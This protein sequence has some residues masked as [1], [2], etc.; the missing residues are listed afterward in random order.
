MSALHLILFFAGLQSMVISKDICEEFTRNGFWFDYGL[1]VRNNDSVS[2]QWLIIH[3]SQTNSPMAWRVSIDYNNNNNT[4]QV[5]RESEDLLSVHGLNITKKYVQSITLK[6]ISDVIPWTIYLY[7]HN[8]RLFDTF[9]LRGDNV[10]QTS[11]AE[12]HYEYENTQPSVIYRVIRATADFEMVKQVNYSDVFVRDGTQAKKFLLND[13]GRLGLQQ[14]SMPLIESLDRMLGV[15]AVFNVV[16]KLLIV[17]NYHKQIKY[18]ISDPQWIV[19]NCHINHFDTT[20]SD[21]IHCSSLTSTSMSTQPM[22]SSSNS[23]S[24]IRTLSSVRHSS[25]TNITTYPTLSTNT[26]FPLILII[27]FVII[28]IVIILTIGLCIVL[29]SRR[30]VDP[31]GQMP[32]S[33]TQRSGKSLSFST[34]KTVSSD[35]TISMEN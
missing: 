24:N 35:A 4:A 11:T 5:I 3:D 13:N 9:R 1:E 28:I 22:I 23:I 14:M 34:I 12:V 32:I 19:H 7:E 21:L 25:A 20:D 27:V 26:I 33:V 16:G 18:C 10:W 2:H 17:T 29:I 8:A 30:N 6:S 31:S 15:T